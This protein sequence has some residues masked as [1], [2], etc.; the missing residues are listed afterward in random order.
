MYCSNCGK[1]NSEDSK[2]CQYCG[3]KLSTKKITTQ[4]IQERAKD[5]NTSKISSE[6]LDELKKRYK[7]T[8][9]TSVALSILGLVLT[10]IVSLTESS[11]LET[12]I[13]TLIFVPFIIP[14]YYFGQK[15]KS[16]GTDDLE[17]SFKISR[18]M[19]IYTGIFCLLNLAMGGLGFLWLLLLYYYFK[20]YIETRNVI[21]NSNKKI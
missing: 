18:G 16:S 10:F 3:T 11:I 13:G 15:L 21:K 14:F 5:I 8:A 9:D 19:L 17:S 7:N 4:N 1:H 6:N 20:S 12:F 2:F